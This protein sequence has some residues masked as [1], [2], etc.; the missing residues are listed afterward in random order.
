MD[1][2]DRLVA[3]LEEQLQE[4]TEEFMSQSREITDVYVSL[5]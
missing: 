1:D 3:K 2:Q 5:G 4:A